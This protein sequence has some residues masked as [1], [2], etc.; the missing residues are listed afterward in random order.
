MARALLATTS[1]L[2]HVEEHPNTL[3]YACP[4]GSPSHKGVPNGDEEAVKIPLTYKKATTSDTNA[5][6]AV[7]SGSE[8]CRDHL[9]SKKSGVSVKFLHGAPL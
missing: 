4:A 1:D 5:I 2:Y 9:R 8:A 7:D 3:A 6:G